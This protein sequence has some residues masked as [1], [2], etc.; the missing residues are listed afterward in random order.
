MRNRV[1]ILWVIVA[2]AI[3]GFGMAA[4]SDSPSS[5]SDTVSFTSGK[6]L[7]SSED[8][9]GSGTVYF[10]LSKDNNNNLSGELQDGSTV[11]KLGGTYNPEIGAYNASAATP[12]SEGDRRYV[13]NG[14]IDP[15]SISRNQRFGRSTLLSQTLGSNS[16]GSTGMITAKKGSGSTEA[17]PIY[18]YS[19][20]TDPGN[21]N[22]QP[23]DFTGGIPAAFHGN[24]IVRDIPFDNDEEDGLDLQTWYVGVSEYFLCLNILNTMKNGE[25]VREWPYECI[26]TSCKE[27]EPGIFELI[28]VLP[29]YQMKQTPTR[30][31]SIPEAKVMELLQEYLDEKGFSDVPASWFQAGVD[32]PSE[33]EGEHVLSAAEMQ[34]FR[35]QIIPQYCVANGIQPTSFYLK[36][37]MQID[38][39]KLMCTWYDDGNS[40]EGLF[41]SLQDA[42]NLSKDTASA[43]ILPF[44][45]Q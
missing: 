44:V 7:K 11:L 4:C 34:I 28:F 37:D 5:S 35:D 45:R 32:G 16:L 33:G 3:I 19:I 41:T 27:T 9:T 29:M 31:A 22:G 36:W 21:I 15:A 17:R 6:F 39:G 23:M 30:V 24:W 40:D 8:T 10:R 2:A 13:I 25:T 43:D 18:A 42:E 12:A 38:S 14:F 1:K 20:E 26:V